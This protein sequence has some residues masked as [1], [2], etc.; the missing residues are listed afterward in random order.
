MLALV[1]M[2]VVS[3]ITALTLCEAKAPTRNGASSAPYLSSGRRRDDLEALAVA[4][5]EVGAYQQENRLPGV[6]SWQVRR[7]VAMMAN[8]RQYREDRLTI[9]GVEW[10]G[11]WLHFCDPDVFHWP[12]VE[13]T[14]ARVLARFEEMRALAGEEWREP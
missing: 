2:G 14:L 1:R 8:D 5:D 10:E 12:H 7:Y 3:S 13:D 9:A 4:V 6:E 11:Y